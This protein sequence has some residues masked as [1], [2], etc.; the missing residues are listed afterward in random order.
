MLQRITYLYQRIDGVLSAC[1]DMYY[2]EQKEKRFETWKQSKTFTWNVENSNTIQY[3][4]EI[5]NI[6]RQFLLNWSRTTNCNNEQNRTT[7][8]H[9]FRRNFFFLYYLYEVKV[10]MMFISPIQKPRE[11]DRM[12]Q[13]EKRI[14]QNVY[15]IA[16]FPMFPVE[17]R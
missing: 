16:N 5:L 14:E 10:W 3:Q 11:T 4:N 1:E 7:I 17:F 15:T 9:W 8:S 13:T 2:I 12:E 6:Y